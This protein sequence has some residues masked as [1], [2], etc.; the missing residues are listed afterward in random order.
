MSAEGSSSFT[1]TLN[2]ASPVKTIAGR[3]TS[4][5]SLASVRE[6][7]SLRTV[8]LFSSTAMT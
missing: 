8:L 5:T 7:S 3:H 1:V 4:V 6:F 2:P